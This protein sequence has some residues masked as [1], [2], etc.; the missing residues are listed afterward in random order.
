MDHRVTKTDIYHDKLKKEHII[1]I[2]I[3]FFMKSCTPFCPFL[4]DSNV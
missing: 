2:A 3:L 4:N 1:T